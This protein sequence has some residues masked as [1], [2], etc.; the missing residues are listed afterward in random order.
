MYINIYAWYD[1][2]EIAVDRTISAHIYK[3]SNPIIFPVGVF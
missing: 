2:W 3:M 1:I